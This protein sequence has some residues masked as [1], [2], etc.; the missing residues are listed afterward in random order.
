MVKAALVVLVAA[1]TLAAPAAASRPPSYLEKISIMDAFNIP[2]RSFSSRCVRIVVST[3][4]PR[5]AYVTSPRHTPK[6]CVQ[7]GEEGNG[8]SLYHRGSRSSIHW[9][10]VV[11]G[12]GVPCQPPAAVRRDLFG[13]STCG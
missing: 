1:A 8:W 10:H 9:T 4:D 5:W 3:V 2:G 13:S 12:D 11:D 7:A 6:A